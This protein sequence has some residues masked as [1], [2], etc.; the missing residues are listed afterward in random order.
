MDTFT[1][2]LGNNAPTYEAL[3]L[4]VVDLIDRFDAPLEVSI[5]ALRMAQVVLDARER[6]AWDA[7]GGMQINP[8]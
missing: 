2:A 4:K 5:V 3:A 8:S 1:S 6:D 7:L